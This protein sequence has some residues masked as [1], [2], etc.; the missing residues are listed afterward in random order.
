LSEPGV[1]SDKVSWKWRCFVRTGCN[2][3]QNPVKVSPFCP[4]LASLQTKSRGS[5]AVLSEPGVTS[6][7][8]SCKRRCFVRTWC[9]FRQNPVKVSPFCPNRV[10]LQTKSHESDAVLSETGITSDKISCKWRCFVRTGYHFRQNP[11]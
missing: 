9:D 11:V 4:K 5:G 6:D 7:K 1:T 2:F 8:S 3:R 10:L